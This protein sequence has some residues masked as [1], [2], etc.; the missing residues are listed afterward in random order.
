MGRSLEAAHAAYVRL[1]TGRKNALV[2][3]HIQPG[4]G[5]FIDE[6]KRQKR[7]RGLDVRLAVP[8]TKSL[9]GQT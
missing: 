9:S 3:R 8:T 6:L 7:T 2:R 4:S 1:S 5:I